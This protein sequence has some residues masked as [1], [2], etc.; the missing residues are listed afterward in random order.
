MPISISGTKILMIKK[1]YAYVKVSERTIYRLAAAKII[2]AFQTA[3]SWRLSLVDIARRIKQQSIEGLGGVTDQHII[4]KQE[5]TG[6]R[7]N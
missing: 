6:S 4:A 1:V 7:W 5:G 3:G 2:P